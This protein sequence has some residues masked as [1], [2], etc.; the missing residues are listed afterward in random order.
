[1]IPPCRAKRLLQLSFRCTAGRASGTT[2]QRPRNSPKRGLA[3]GPFARIW[4][5]PPRRSKT[6]SAA[7][8]GKQLADDTT[9]REETQVRASAVDRGEERGCGVRFGLFSS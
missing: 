6:T 8:D 7:D 2:S 5:P 1:M 4:V 9:L 3:P